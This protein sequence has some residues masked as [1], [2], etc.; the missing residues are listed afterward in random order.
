MKIDATAF[1]NQVVTCKGNIHVRNK[2]LAK[3]NSADEGSPRILMLSLLNSASGTQLEA[4]SHVILLD[5]VVGTQGEAQAVDAQAIARC[6][7]LGQTRPVEVVRFVVQNSIE[8]ND[9]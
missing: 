1:A 6:N 9:Y 8:Q 4:A 3:F 2:I 5:P 7:R